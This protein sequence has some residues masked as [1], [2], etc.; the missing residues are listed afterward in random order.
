[1]QAVAHMRTVLQALQLDATRLEVVLIGRKF[2]P[3]C[4]QEAGQQLE[5]LA[6][7]GALQVLV[8]GESEEERMRRVPFRVKEDELVARGDTITM[9]VD[10]L[11]L[12][13][14]I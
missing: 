4:T 5:K 8:T 1:M 6:S 10:K 11:T 14:T 7:H 13:G 12:A 3:R 9:L 2:E